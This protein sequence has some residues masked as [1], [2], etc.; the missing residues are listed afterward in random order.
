[1][2]APNHDVLRAIIGLEAANPGAFKVVKDWI[3]NS[4]IGHLMAASRT[5]NE[6]T[7]RWMQGRCQELEDI[8]RFIA[9]AKDML[10][11]QQS[12]TTTQQAASNHFD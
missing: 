1:M 9:Q 7:L 4:W 10:D 11:A 5:D 2:L 6:I 12:S 3:S 8:G